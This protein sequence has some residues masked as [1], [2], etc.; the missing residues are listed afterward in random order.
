MPK[1]PADCPGLRLP[2]HAAFRDTDCS[3]IYDRT[4]RNRMDNCRPGWTRDA[5]PRN[6]D[7]LA[8][9]NCIRGAAPRESE[10]TFATPSDGG[11]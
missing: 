2:H 3:A 7:G 6:P 10:S 4:S 5:S 11:R 9:D 1:F 8:I